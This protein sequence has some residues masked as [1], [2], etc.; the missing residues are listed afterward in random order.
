VQAFLDMLT[1]EGLPPSN[2]LADD[3]L[4]NLWSRSRVVIARFH[5]YFRA[6]KHA[7]ADALDT[8]PHSNRSSA[9]MTYVYQ[10][11]TTTTGELIDVGL[12]YSDDDLT[13]PPQVYRDAP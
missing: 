4:T 1:E 5:D 9:Q 11:F 3:E 7:I 8:K 2:P 13:L 10:D 12:N 6:C